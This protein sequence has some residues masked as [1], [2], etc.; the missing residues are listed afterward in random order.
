MFTVDAGA[1][2]NLAGLTITGGYSYNGN[3]GG[4]DN[5]ATLRVTDC[6]IHN[7]LALS[8]GGGIFNGGTLTVTDSDITANSVNPL[9]YLGTGT[10]GGINN[11]GTMTISDSTV[12]G[13][14]AEA[15]DAQGGGIASSGTLTVTNSTISANTAMSIYGNYNYGASP[16][17]VGFGGGLYL[18]GTTSIANVTISGNI[19]AGGQGEELTGGRYPDAD[20]S[21]GYY[22]YQGSPGG[23]AGGGGL[24][25]EGG[26]LTLVNSTIYGN[27]AIGGNGASVYGNVPG[28]GWGNDGLGGQAWG[29]GIGSLEGGTASLVN[30]TITGNS[31]SGG[32]GG[33]EWVNN[34]PWFY[35]WASADYQLLASQAV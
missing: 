22:Y 17:D 15:A 31:A 14:T 9:Y 25:L 34:P 7:N 27:T 8:G 19:A 26:L 20:S 5:W 23:P 3:G 29:G 18:T 32:S 30:C 16:V 11:A 24:E 2:V 13:N 21:G 12:S 33:G 6:T 4:I 1:N 10:G 35:G 28:P